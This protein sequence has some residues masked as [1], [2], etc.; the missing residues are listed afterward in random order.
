ML[1]VCGIY[2]MCSV[3]VMYIVCVSYMYVRRIVLAMSVV[4]VVYVCIV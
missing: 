3:C 1:C 4:S 2:V